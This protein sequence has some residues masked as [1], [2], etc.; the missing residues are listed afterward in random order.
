M[1][2]SLLIFA[3]ASL[4]DLWTTLAALAGDSAREA[5][6]IA[7]AVWERSGPAGLAAFKLGLDGLAAAILWTCRRNKWAPPAA[8]LAAALTAGAVALWCWSC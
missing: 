3:V 1:P 6:P 7:R 2:L 5:N 4:L 8:W